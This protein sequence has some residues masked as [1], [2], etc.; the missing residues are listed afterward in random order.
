MRSGVSTFYCVQFLQADFGY[1]TKQATTTSH[2]NSRCVCVCVC[3]ATLV[4]LT[5]NAD[6]VEGF[7]GFNQR[8]SQGRVQRGSG[9]RQ[10]SLVV[11]RGK[12]G[13]A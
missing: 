11:T 13:A 9:G 2:V 3:G 10:A 4:I 5:S 12:V 6:C 8:C 1:G 7:L